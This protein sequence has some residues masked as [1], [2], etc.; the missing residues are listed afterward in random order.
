M[1]KYWENYWEYMYE[2]GSEKGLLEQDEKSR[3]YEKIY[4]LTIKM[5]SFC[6]FSGDPVAETQHS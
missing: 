6:D 3:S 5:W 1:G 4:K 2:F